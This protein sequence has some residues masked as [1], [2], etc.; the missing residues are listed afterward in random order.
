MVVPSLVMGGLEMMVVHLSAALRE[1]GIDVQVVSLDGEGALD[2]LAG[3]MNVPVHHVPSRGWKTLV[4]SSPLS[5]FIASFQ[6]AI[7]HSH[8]GSWARA[9]AAS[10][11]SGIG[12]VVHTIHGFDEYGSRK[13]RWMERLAGAFTDKVVT[14]SA[15]LSA[16]ASADL[17]IPVRKVV[18]VANGVTPVEFN[19]AS[20]KCF[21][22]AWSEKDPVV[23]AVGRLVEVK[24]HATLIKAMRLVVAN[25]PNARLIIVGGG[26]LRE[27]LEALVSVSDLLNSVHFAGER[28]DARL[29]MSAAS[30]FCL[31]SLSEG[32]SLSLL[33]AMASAL[34]V[35][36]T[37]VGESPNIVN[38]KIG[39]LVPSN[40]AESLASA[41]LDLLNDP[42]KGRRMGEAGKELVEQKYSMRRTMFHYL[43]IYRQIAPNPAEASVIPTC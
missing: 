34:P 25:Y 33:E 42:E 32:L 37:A 39:H 24:A 9:V 29:I 31:P 22:S 23:V 8:N 13:L 30:V 5:Q 28:S 27:E 11:I 16:H 3:Q 2:A 43:Q 10:R 38:S 19:D 14:V 36:V 4:R 12:R 26:P 20:P 40:S 21:P 15:E 41:L 18:L 1:K 35:V 6:P 17:W 7:I